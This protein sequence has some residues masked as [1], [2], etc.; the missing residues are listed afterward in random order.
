M[1]R[2]T[3]RYRTPR[4]RPVSPVVMLDVDDLELVE[5]TQRRARSYRRRYP[6]AISDRELSRLVDECTAELC[7]LAYE[8]FCLR[9]R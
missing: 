3:M 1:D 9:L 7:L 4:P 2:R 8:R 6:P 5:E